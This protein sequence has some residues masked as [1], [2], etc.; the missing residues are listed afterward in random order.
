MMIVPGRL[1]ATVK[2]KQA[3]AS[4]ILEESDMLGLN[5]ASKLSSKLDALVLN[6]ASMITMEISQSML[7][8]RSI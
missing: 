6:G 5:A 2:R 4:A 7:H 3:D 1:Q 8:L